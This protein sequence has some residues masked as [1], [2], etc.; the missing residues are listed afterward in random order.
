MGSPCKAS[1]KDAT[2]EFR[3]VYGKKGGYKRVLIKERYKMINPLIRVC[4]V[5]TMAVELC[6]CAHFR[7]GDT[8]PVLHQTSLITALLE[9]CYDGVI[10]CGELRRQGD[11]GIGTFDRLDGEMILL[12]GTIFQAK[13][14]GSV[15]EAADSLRVPFAAVTAFKPDQMRAL[16]S[17]ADLN[18]LKGKLDALRVSDNRFYAI[19]VEGVFDA[20]KFRSVP[21]QVKP[22]PKLTEVAARQPVFERKAIQGTLVGF[23]C[24]EYAKTLN[25]PGYHL[26]FISADRK[27]GGHVLGCS[28]R[29]GTGRS[30]SLSEVHLIL[31]RTGEFDAVQLSGDSARA[32]KAAESGK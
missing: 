21:A 17:A 20:V 26:H 9:G 13:S 14:D 22:Y 23:W 6:S 11:F 27:S 15:V 4:V 7:A 25:L 24:P 2:G 19:R 28:L 3:V 1:G 32:L 8:A 18:V 31:P 29:Q 12:E 30:G 16:G 10:S 5:M